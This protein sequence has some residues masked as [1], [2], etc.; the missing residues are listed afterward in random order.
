M[1]NSLPPLPSFSLHL[2]FCYA[3]YFLLVWTYNNEAN[4]VMDM[5]GVST[6]SMVTLG[7]TTR[8]GTSVRLLVIMRVRDRCCLGGFWTQRM[9]LWRGRA[10]MVVDLSSE[11]LKWLGVATLKIQRKRDVCGST[12]MRASWIHFRGFNPWVL[13][14]FLVPLW[15]SSNSLGIKSKLSY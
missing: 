2:N 6:C 8:L 5:L 12:Y 9:L 1:S 11:Q 13:G 4:G 14:F 7:G 10:S 15:A 3:L